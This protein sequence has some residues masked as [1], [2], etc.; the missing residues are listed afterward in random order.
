MFSILAAPIYISTNSVDGL[1]FPHTLSTI[2]SL[3]TLQ[4]F[5]IRE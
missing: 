2:H 4:S 5:F 3:Y 1:P